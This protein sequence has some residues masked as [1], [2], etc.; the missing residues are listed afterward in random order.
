MWKRKNRRDHFFPSIEYFCFATFCLKKIYIYYWK[1]SNHWWKV[2]Y[3]VNN[4]LPNKMLSFIYCPS[5]SRYVQKCANSFNV[6]KINIYNSL[7]SFSLS[8]IIAGMGH[9]TFCKLNSWELVEPSHSTSVDN[10]TEEY[11]NYEGKKTFYKLH[12]LL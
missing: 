1:F 12:F 11:F 2:L 3:C 9:F 4:I 8:S 7:L 10:L 6:F 5:I